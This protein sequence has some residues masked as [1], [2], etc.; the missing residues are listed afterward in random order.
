MI[1][2]ELR[3]RTGLSQNEFAEY[4][5]IPLRTIQ[6]WEQGRREP[7]DYILKMMF[8]IWNFENQS[9]IKPANKSKS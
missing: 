7:S 3:Q 9:I 4:F 1:I 5:E 8:R 2:K 6:E